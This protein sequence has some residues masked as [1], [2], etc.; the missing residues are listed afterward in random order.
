M[1]LSLTLNGTSESKG[2]LH[3]GLFRGAHSVLQRITSEDDEPYT[4]D[5][6]ICKCVFV[7][8]CVWWVVEESAKVALFISMNKVLLHNR[9][10]NKD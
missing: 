8:V 10:C 4:R 9:M 2:D 3:F 7:C 1:Q 5:Y 6:L